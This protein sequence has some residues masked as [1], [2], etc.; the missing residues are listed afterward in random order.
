MGALLL[1]LGRMGIVYFCGG[2]SSWMGLAARGADAKWLAAN[3]GFALD[4]TLF[5]KERMVYLFSCGGLLFD[6]VMVPLLLWRRTR[7]FAVAFALAFHLTNSQLPLPTSSY[8]LPGRGG[9]AAF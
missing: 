4:R 3:M 5:A 6:L 1:L 2:W 7:R 9:S 8:R